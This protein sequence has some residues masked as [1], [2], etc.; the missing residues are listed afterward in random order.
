VRR[1]VGVAVPVRVP[2][3]A[4]VTARVGPGVADGWLSPA[5]A[6]GDGSEPA[7]GCGVADGRGVG[8][9]DEGTGPGVVIGSDGAGL[10]S[11]APLAGTPLTRPR[12]APA[13][14]AARTAAAGRGT[15][16]IRSP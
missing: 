4:P 3:A 12:P 7:V 9:L 6:V 5:V 8:R 11:L 16:Y 2:L 13:S 15:T 14:R 10:G 1:T